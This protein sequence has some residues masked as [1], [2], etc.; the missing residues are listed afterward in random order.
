MKSRRHIRLGRQLQALAATLTI[1]ALIGGSTAFARL[2]ASQ[3]AELKFVASQSDVPF[4]GNF[5]KFSADVDF[6]PAKPVSG[7]VN[8]VIDLGSVDTG[9]ADADAMLRGKDF[10]DAARFPQ[11]TFTS[12][13]IAAESAGRFRAIGQFTLKGRSLALAV[14]FAARPEAAGTWFEGSVPVARLA[15]KV[16]EGEWADTGTLADQVL[17]TFKL[18]VPR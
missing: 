13:A 18:F 5:R 8:I 17:I 7:K 9:S 16:G 4:A 12:T 15:Y 1:T 3:G 6:D 11:A 14:P 2:A 10:F